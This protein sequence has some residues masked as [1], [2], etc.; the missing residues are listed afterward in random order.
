MIT[1]AFYHLFTLFVGACLVLRR[2]PHLRL[3]RCRAPTLRAA[4]SNTSLVATATAPAYTNG[5]AHAHCSSANG[6]LGANGD[7]LAPPVDVHA[8]QQAAAT[9]PVA[10][11]PAM[12]NA[13]VAVFGA[14]V[15]GAVPVQA[16][17]SPPETYQAVVAVGTSKAKL[18]VRVPAA[19]A[20]C[21]TNCLT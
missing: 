19:A 10:A 14:G 11:V 3:R 4:A 8:V 7:A 21:G 20:C 12:A 17:F 13:A 1:D 18:P 5:T 2:L 16:M 15:G 6:A 9:Q